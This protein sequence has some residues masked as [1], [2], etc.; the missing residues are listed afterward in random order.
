MLDDGKSRHENYYT[1]MRNSLIKLYFR[2]IL[3]VFFMTIIA[4]FSAVYYTY[5][6]GD[7]IR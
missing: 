1:L 6:V 3:F 7:L 5:L 4:E 2:D